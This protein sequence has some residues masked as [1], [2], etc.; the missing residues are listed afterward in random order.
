MKIATVFAVM[1]SATAL[2]ACGGGDTTTVIERPPGNQGGGSGSAGGG[3]GGNAGGGTESVS[4]SAP[5]VEGL[6]LPTAKKQLK[7][8][9]YSADVQTD[10]AFG[11]IVPSNFTVCSQEDA[12]GNVVPIEVDNH[13]C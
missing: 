9:G 8:A 13:G 7:G 12:Q 3:G 1:A 2:A 5:D 6:S 10:A 11:V 4:G